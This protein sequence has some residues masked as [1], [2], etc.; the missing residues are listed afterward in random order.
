MRRDFFTIAQI[1]VVIQKGL[2]SIST[3]FECFKNEHCHLHGS[4]DNSTGQCTCDTKW[5][6]SPDCTG[7]LLLST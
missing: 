5:K 1:D 3:E 2:L 4:C 6:D 7:N